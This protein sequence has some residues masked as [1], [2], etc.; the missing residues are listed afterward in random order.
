MSGEILS[1]HFTV[2]TV[3]R[4]LNTELWEFV[5]GRQDELET[6]VR[7]TV[8]AALDS[9][10]QVWDIDYRVGSLEIVVILGTGYYAIAHY[11]DFV[12][13]VGTL[14]SQMRSLLRRFFGR[15]SPTPFSI[16]GGWRPGPA[17][18]RV[19]TS[20]AAAPA[21]KGIPAWHVAHAAAL[22]YLIASH[23]V[24]IGAIIWL[25]SRGQ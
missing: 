22:W 13:S 10:I 12:Q 18:H 6:E 17:L 25:L 9:S 11:D 14:V 23:A 16:I 24:L 4:D 21:S 19:E 20:R 2:S 15:R 1:I 5:S 7:R 8:E 3:D